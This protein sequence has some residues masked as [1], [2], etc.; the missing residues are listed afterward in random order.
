VTTRQSSE[1][2]QQAQQLPE[3]PPDDAPVRQRILNAAFSAFMEGGYAQ[4]STLEIATRAHVSKR[5]L[6]ALVGNKQ[7]MLVA[8][9]AERAKRF[10]VPPDLPEPRDRETLARVLT[11]FGAHLLREVSDPTVIAV[12]RLAIAEAV[13]APEV[14][15]TLDTVAREANQGA[16]RGILAQAQSFGLLNGDPAGMAEQFAGLL[17]GNLLIGLLLCVAEQP[18]AAEIA[19]RADAATAAFL[20]LHPHPAGG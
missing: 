1:Q 4:T 11:A 7:E 20:R 8:C 9:I 3:Q 16:V 6:Y 14:A 12:F 5:A 18:G 17:W 13:R 19:R 15:R 10:R 2:P